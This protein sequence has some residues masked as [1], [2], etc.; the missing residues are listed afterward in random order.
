MSPKQARTGRQIPSPQVLRALLALRELIL[1]GEWPVDQ[2]LSEPQLVGRVGV[3][4]TPLR[5]AMEILEHEGLVERRP[6]GGFAVRSFTLAD[7]EEAVMLRGTLE[8]TLARIAAERQAPPD[9]S[10]MEPALYEMDGLLRRELTVDILT[11]YVAANDRF[12]RAL[13]DLVHSPLLKRLMRQIVSVPFA[14]PNAFFM[15]HVA[16]PEARQVLMTA[17]EQHHAIVDAIAQRQGSRV[18]AL[19]REHARLVLRFLHSALRDREAFRRV[20]GGVLIQYPEFASL[21]DKARNPSSDPS[22]IAR[23]S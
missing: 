14:S 10:Q 1:T 19:T 2:R 18:E 6:G 8:G 7:I 12:H 3:S 13:L 17:Q 5:L 16:T 21:K 11:R 23:P 20:P 9:L 4:R 22:P 15:A